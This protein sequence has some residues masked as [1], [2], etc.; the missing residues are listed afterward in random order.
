MGRQSFMDRGNRPHDGRDPGTAKGWPGWSRGSKGEHV[1]RGGG[2]GGRARPAGL[3]AQVRVLY[4]KNINKSM[5]SF[6]QRRDVIRFVLSN[7]HLD[8]IMVRTAAGTA[9]R[10]F[11][12]RLGRR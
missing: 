9:V 5:K 3:V 2:K 4:L 8:W 6:K 7:D 10:S 1:V 11:C 12:R